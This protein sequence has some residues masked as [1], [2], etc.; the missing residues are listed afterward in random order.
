L[1]WI[2][3]GL[4]W[5]GN[6]VKSWLKPESSAPAFTAKPLPTAPVYITPGGAWTPTPAIT[7]T[8]FNADGD[9]IADFVQSIIDGKSVLT[10][11]KGVQ[12]YEGN[13]SGNSSCTLMTN[14]VY[15]L[16]GLGLSALS[17]TDPNFGRTTP[18]QQFYSAQNGEIRFVLNPSLLPVNVKQADII[19]AFQ[20]MSGGTLVRGAVIYTHRV[21]VYENQTGYNPTNDLGEFGHSM[22]SMGNGQIAEMSGPS[23]WGKNSGQYIGTLNIDPNFPLPYQY[24]WKPSPTDPITTR[25]LFDT[26]T[27]Y[28]TLIKG[29]LT[30]PF[31]QDYV[32]KGITKGFSIVPA[33]PVNIKDLPYYGINNV[34]TWMKIVPQQN[35]YTYWAGDD[36][37]TCYLNPATEGGLLQ[38]LYC[39]PT[40][41][42]TST[43]TP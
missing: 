2:G 7:P 20:Q 9:R 24:D 19:Q 16:N 32:V 34:D 5:A 40:V 27:P 4:E 6:K 13:I 35:G 28:D 1:C 23:Y 36:G 31:Q 39:P 25:S 3:K 15:Y 29:D 8:P 10:P 12:F 26:S 22:I 21:E 37:K 43:P 30:T 17:P 33:Q 41:A 42:P 18:S 38:Q 14:T 11:P